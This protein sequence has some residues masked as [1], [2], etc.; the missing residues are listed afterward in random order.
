MA[1]TEAKTSDKKPPATADKA[2]K[3]RRRFHH[4]SKTGCI[5]CK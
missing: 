1:N 4:K 3:Q 2:P 5:T